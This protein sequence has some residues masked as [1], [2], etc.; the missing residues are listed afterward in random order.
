MKAV[1]VAG[2]AFTASHDGQSVTKPNRLYEKDLE[3]RKIIL[4]CTYNIKQD[5]K[6]T[7]KIT[8]RRVRAANVAVEK[9]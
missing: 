4:F 9:Q 5:R 1:A 8:L 6:C 3:L 7:H 2:I